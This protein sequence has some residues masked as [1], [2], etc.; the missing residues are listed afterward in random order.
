MSDSEGQASLTSQVRGAALWSIALVSSRTILAFLFGLLLARLLG[1]EPF[2]LI[3][4]ALVFIA[5]GQLLVDAG[6]GAALVQAK[7]LSQ[8]LVRSA[9]TLQF[10][11]GLVF[12]IGLYCL[13]SSLASFFG[14]AG[15][16]PVLQWL[17]AMFLIQAVGIVP[18]SLM[19]RELR[20]R[21]VYEIYLVS[22]ATSFGLVALPLAVAGRGVI[23]LIAGQLLFAAISSLWLSL[24]RRHSWR[25]RNP[26]REMALLGFGGRVVLVNMVNVV[27]ENADRL[28]VARRLT[29]NET[30]LYSRAYS[31]ARI[32]VDSFMTAVSSSL[33]S[34]FSRRTDDTAASARGYIAALNAASLV[35]MP[36]L[37]VLAVAAEQI[38]LV[39]YGPA[40]IG[41]SGAMSVLAIGMYFHIATAVSGPLL[42]ANNHVTV[43]LVASCVALAVMLAGL[44]RLGFSLLAAA[45]IVSIAYAVRAVIMF[46]RVTSLLSLPTGRAA[47]AWL[48]GSRLAM[49][50]LA[51]SL[52]TA[53]LPALPAVLIDAAALCT[54]WA[55]V[56]RKRSTMEWSEELRGAMRGFPKSVPVLGGSVDPR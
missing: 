45:W 53:R 51:V 46:L 24:R 4:I 12:T 33:L 52:L 17:S 1:P 10:L 30:G 55:L 13:S 18:A 2:G 19:R 22:Y 50:L 5:V 31:T 49:V 40:W 56:L 8:E 39:L 27:L 38:T 54:A 43:E 36:A 25:P 28:F 3:A 14:M 32:G 41:M 37:V 44:W 7:E 47:L 42:W 48:R 23:S 20:Q 29:A 15:L 26:L 16:A 11:L 35:L 6:V 9:F 34:G 21:E